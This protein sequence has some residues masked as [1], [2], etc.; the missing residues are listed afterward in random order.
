MCDTKFLIASAIIDKYCPTLR[1]CMFKLAEINF[2]GE[3]TRHTEVGST[4]FKLK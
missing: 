2:K 1:D 3:I 4:T